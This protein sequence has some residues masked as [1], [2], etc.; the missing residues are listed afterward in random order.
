MYPKLGLSCI[1]VD[2]YRYLFIFDFIVLILQLYN[3]R[4]YSN[5]V[6]NY[7]N[8][9]MLF[10]NISKNTKS[11]VNVRNNYVPCFARK[12][13]SSA[14]LFNFANILFTIFSLLSFTFL[15]HFSLSLHLYSHTQTLTHS[16]TSKTR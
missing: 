1:F 7:E 3:N 12:T 9:K 6:F 5:K 10:K 4:D 16:A 8:S 14:G 2:I 15:S 11:F 13:H